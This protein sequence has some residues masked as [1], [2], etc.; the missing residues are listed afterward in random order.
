VTLLSTAAADL[1]YRKAKKEEK[2]PE[3]GK[4]DV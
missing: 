4:L 2:K 1:T 3:Q